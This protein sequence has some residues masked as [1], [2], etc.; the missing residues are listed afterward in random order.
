MDVVIDS[1]GQAT[2]EKSMRITPLKVAMEESTSDTNPDKSGN[3]ET[4]TF[5]I[6]DKINRIVIIPE[7]SWTI[8]RDL[9]VPSKMLLK[10]SA[11][12]KIDLVKGADLISYSPVHVDGSEELPVKI[13]SS[14]SAGSCMRVIQAN[15]Q[16]RFS[17]VTFDK[18]SLDDDLALQ[19]ICN[20][21]PSW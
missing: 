5:I 20:L 4:F 18:I 17:H 9:I 2:W 15:K 12:A 14:D 19:F 21:S 6:A 11:G 7:G 13:V 8:S 1:A 10:I 3:Y 16:S